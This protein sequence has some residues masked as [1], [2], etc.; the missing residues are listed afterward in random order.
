MFPYESV[1][2]ERFRGDVC[3]SDNNESSRWLYFKMFLVWML[4]TA[5]EIEVITL[6]RT[7]AYFPVI[8]TSS[9]WKDEGV[10]Q[11]SGTLHCAHVHQEGHQQ[12][13]WPQYC[14]STQLYCPV[15][16]L[17]FGEC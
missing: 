17:Y 13:L 14:C 6:D 1:F 8:N 3:Q 4:F 15:S 16:Q 12:D 11:A 9:S 2:A 10:G 7:A 5:L